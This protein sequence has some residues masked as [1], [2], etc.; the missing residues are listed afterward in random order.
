MNSTQDELV[1][2]ALHRIS[3]H[4][5]DTLSTWLGKPTVIL[6][7]DLIRVPF[8]EAVSTLGHGGQPV[9]CCCIELT[10]AVKGCLILVFSDREGLALAQILTGSLADEEDGWNELRIS[11][12]LETANIL[13]SAYLNCLSG[14]LSSDE[15]T[16][17]LLPSPPVFQRDFPECL[18]QFAL[19]QQA[20]TGENAVFNRTR[21]EIAGDDLHCTLLFIP[22]A[23]TFD[24][25]S[26]TM[27]DSPSSDG[28]SNR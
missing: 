8:A 7:D 17:E 22:D 13:G 18:M 20:A 12:V 19:L 2:R 24:T 27:F 6:L 5:S 14:I 16:V 10:G 26:S 15:S 25:I 9:C 28:T 11:A 23:N 21:I 4:L 1:K 3:D